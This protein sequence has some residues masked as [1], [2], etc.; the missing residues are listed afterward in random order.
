M[1]KKFAKC[2]FCGLISSF[3]IQATP[4]CPKCFKEKHYHLPENNR[5]SGTNGPTYSISTSGLN[6]TASPSPSITASTTTLEDEA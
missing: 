2:V 1:N 3:V 4:I 6:A 5:E